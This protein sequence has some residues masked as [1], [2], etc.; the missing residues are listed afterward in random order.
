M[1]CQRRLQATDRVLPA[2]IV[3][4]VGVDPGNIRNFGSW[5]S[6]EFELVHVDCENTSLDHVIEI[7]TK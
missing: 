7:V 2:Y 5:L 3:E 1:K 6:G 4:K